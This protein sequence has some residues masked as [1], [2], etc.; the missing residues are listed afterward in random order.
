M[1][2]DAKTGQAI[3]GSYGVGRGN[4]GSYQVSG[5]PWITGSEIGSGLEHKISFPTITKS[6]TVIASGTMTGDLHVYFASTGSSAGSATDILQS[7]FSGGHYLTLNS[8]EDSI[9]LNV[10]CKEIYLLARQADVGYE[11]FAELTNIPTS[12]MFDL[13]GSGI[14]STGTCPHENAHT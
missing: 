3:F 10:K 7:R 12:S 5:A 6:V 13:T 4:V 9:T 1:A 14:S 8:A 2:T 11:L